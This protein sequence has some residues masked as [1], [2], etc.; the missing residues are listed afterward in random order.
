MT[1]WLRLAPPPAPS[2][3]LL[4]GVLAFM[5]QLWA[6]AHRLDTT[7]KRM[8]RAL[9]VTGPQRL[10]LRVVGLA[11]GTS[12]GDLA[13]TLHVHPSTLTG[14]LKRLGAQG[15]IH[16]R[17]DP[18]DARRVCLHLTRAGARVNQRRAG[19]VEAA[20]QRA[21]IQAAPGDVEAASRLL[22]ALCAALEEDD[23]ARVPR[24][25]SERRAAPA[26]S[27]HVSS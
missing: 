18:D 3:W 9:G 26:A 24:R 10:V 25:R 1:H 17:P 21:L 7:S 23:T 13:A 22:A 6:T 27:R 5:Q 11:P 14:V 12:A 20:V 4:P 15:L 2:P 19:T 16:R 8:N